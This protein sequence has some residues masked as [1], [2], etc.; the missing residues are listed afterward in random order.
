MLGI[1]LQIGRVKVPNFLIDSGAGCN[2]VDKKTWRWLKNKNIKADTRKSAKTLCTYDSSKP[3]PTLKT[4][5]AKVI[6]K[7]T[8]SCCVADFVVMNSEGHSR[9]L[10][11]DT[12]EC[13]GLLHVGPVQINLMNSSDFLDRFCELFDGVGM[14]K[15]YDLERHVD[16][17]LTPIAQP[18]RRVPFQLREEVDKKLD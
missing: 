5:T 10:D 17:S 8:K 6:S 14:L 3:L 1:T 13:L 15:S 12:A 11:R 9:L 7:N 18:L 16:S 4:F 2:V